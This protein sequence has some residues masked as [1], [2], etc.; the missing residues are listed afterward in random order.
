MNKVNKYLIFSFYSLLISITVTPAEAEPS[1]T[2]TKDDITYI[3]AFRFEPL[4]NEYG[5]TDRA[6]GGLALSGDS[7][8]LYLVGKNGSIAEYEIPEIVNS[9]DINDLNTTAPATQ[10]FAMMLAAS[11]TSQA[12][13]PEDLDLN[14]VTGL[15]LINNQLYMYTAIYYDGG[16]TQVNTTFAIADPGNLKESTIRGYFQMEGKVHA[17]G[18]FSPIPTEFQNMLGGDYIAGHAA[19]FPINARH[20]MGPSLFVFN[21]E[22][23]QSAE[24]NS[25]VKTTPLID[26]DINNLLHEDR[27]NET[28][29]NDMWTEI[30]EAHYGFIIP[31]TATYLVVGNSGGHKDGIGYKITQSDGHLCGGSCAYNAEDYYNYMWLYNIN[32]LS[33]VLNHEKQ[34]S[35]IIPYD[36]GE[37]ETK[38]MQTNVNI[39]SKVSAAVYDKNKNLLY[40]TLYNADRNGY[41]YYP[42]CLVYKIA[43]DRPSPPTSIRIL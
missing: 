25:V 13:T 24:A 7:E 19:N 4:T 15:A 17:A 21:S 12:T 30:S 11:K 20:S 27:F 9:W 29:N 36:F 32:D 38:F 14:Y 35:D 40:V 26:Y 42:L 39:P 10:P 22:D 18:W 5:A 16:V 41:A 1:R 23:L 33:S 37:L 6:K 3:G 43:L 28:L 31:G 8:S 34:P 2:I